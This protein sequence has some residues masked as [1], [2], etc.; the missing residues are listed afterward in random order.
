M[1]SIG[2]PSVLGFVVHLDPSCLHPVAVGVLRVEMDSLGPVRPDGL[3]SLSPA[4]L[5]RLPPLPPCRKASCRVLVQACSCGRSFGSLPFPTRSWC[6]PW[7]VFTALNCLLA[8]VGTLA[9]ALLVAPVGFTLFSREQLHLGLSARA[10]L[11]LYAQDPVARV[12]CLVVCFSFPC[13]FAAHSLV[14]LISR[15]V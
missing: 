15:G 7:G 11:R 4:S 13:L 8:L 6:P 1:Q 10:L 14:A 12:F 3:S 9:R 5:R 2:S